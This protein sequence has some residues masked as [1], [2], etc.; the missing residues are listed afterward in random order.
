[1]AWDVLGRSLSDLANALYSSARAARFLR[2]FF[3]LISGLI[4]RWASN[5]WRGKNM[6]NESRAIMIAIWMLIISSFTGAAQSGDDAWK[7]LVTKETEYYR[8]S[9]PASW[10]QMDFGTRPEQFFEASGT[11]LPVTHNKAPVIVTVWIDKIEEAG[12]LNEAK[13]EIVKHYRSTP[14]REFPEGFTH[15]EETITLQSGEKAYLLNTR[16]YRKSKG[17]H[18]SRYDLVMYSPKAKSAYL[19]TL[20]VQYYDA[21]Y[22]FERQ[23]KLKE[24]AKRLYESFQLKGSPNNSRQPEIGGRR[25]G[26]RD[27]TT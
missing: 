21:E 9:V 7:N 22:Q 15:E 20:S 27:V 25:L 18:Q 17:L 12:N 10:R 23:F 4:K 8:F 1:M 16:F 6:K 5:L 11:F 26:F 19:Y 13:E 14:D 24:M 3:V 2:L